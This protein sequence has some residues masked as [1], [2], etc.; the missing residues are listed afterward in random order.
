MQD[1]EKLEA[2]DSDKLSDTALQVSRAPLVFRSSPEKVRTDASLR[3][4]IPKI[5]LYCFT[6]NR[7]ARAS[8]P[9]K[10]NMLLCLLLCHAE[11]HCMP[12]ACRYRRAVKTPGMHLLGLPYRRAEGLKSCRELSCRP[13][14]SQKQ[15]RTRYIYIY[16]CTY[17][18]YFQVYIYIARRCRNILRI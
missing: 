10:T 3:S 9:N 15:L 2:A 6:S 8:L 12:K 18:D 14:N 17:I 16:I 1:S 7:P 5:S 11:T 13:V 4:Q